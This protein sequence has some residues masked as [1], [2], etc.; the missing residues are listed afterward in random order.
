MDQSQYSVETQAPVNHRERLPVPLTQGETLECHVE[1]Q[2]D[3]EVTN[4]SFANTN[5]KGVAEPKQDRRASSPSSKS[6]C[7]P[8]KPTSR[9]IKENLFSLF[10]NDTDIVMI[11]STPISIVEEPLYMH[12]EAA[13][14]C[15]SCKGQA[16]MDQNGN[17][18]ALQ[19]LDF[20]QQ[21][22]WLSMMTRGQLW[23]PD[24]VIKQMVTGEDI[25]A[26]HD[27]N[28]NVVRK[29][30][31]WHQHQAT[32]TRAREGQVAF[33]SEGFC[34]EKRVISRSAVLGSTCKTPT[35]PSTSAKA[36]STNALRPFQFA[37]LPASALMIPKALV[38]PKVLPISGK[39]V[40]RIKYHS[41]RAHL[42]HFN[43]RR[44]LATLVLESLLSQGRA[45]LVADAI[46]A[47]G[48]R[49]RSQTAGKMVDSVCCP[50]LN[51]DPLQWDDD[52]HQL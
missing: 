21:V 35:D 28:E 49:T 43:N 48:E 26:E 12:P 5:T 18:V 9:D 11:D 1:Q 19:D 10:T 33:K 8:P 44:S 46:F 25:T 29:S 50:S 20:H 23:I 27:G 40:Y 38:I 2:Q 15:L 34:E 30:P 7:E 37:P 31:A 17:I 42:N 41:T 14:S 24:D 47:G 6:D 22:A 3:D 52:W 39:K 45:I 32:M 4:I 13:W 51:T 36:S 16:F